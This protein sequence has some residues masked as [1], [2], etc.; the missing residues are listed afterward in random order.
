[1]ILRRRTYL[2][3]LW[4]SYSGW[5]RAGLSRRGALQAALIVAGSV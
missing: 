2:V 4:R 1:M 3:R 5:R